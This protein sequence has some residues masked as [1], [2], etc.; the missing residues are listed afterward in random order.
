MMRRSLLIL[1]A[2]CA[3]AQEPAVFRSTTQ[4]IQIDVAAEDKNG[5]PVADLTRDD[6]ELRVSGKPRAIDTFTATSPAPVVTEPLPRGTFSNRT[7]I[8]EVTQ[9]RYTAFVLDCRNTN[10]T[11]QTFAIQQLRKMLETAPPDGKVALYL[12]DNGFQIAQEFTSNPDLLKEKAAGL[13][14][15]APPAVTDLEQAEAAA[16]DTVTAF[17]KI[18]AH[19]AGISGQKIVVWLSTGFPDNEPAPPPVDSPT[20]LTAVRD[21]PG[22][23]FL[24]DIDEAVNILGNANVVLESAEASYPGASVSPD[25]GPITTHVNPLQMIAERTG[26]RFFPA[27]SA[28]MAA[29]L[30]RAAIDHMSGYELGFYDDG[31]RPPGFVPIEVRV[32]RAGVSVRHREGFYAQPVP[33]PA[34]SQDLLERAVDAITIP[35]TAKVTRTAGNH[36]TLRLRLNVDANALTLRQDGNLWRTR[37]AFFTRFAS[38]VEDQVGDVPLDSPELTLTQAQHDRALREGINLRFTVKAKEGAVTLRVLVRD[39]SSGAAGTVTIPLSAI[40]EAY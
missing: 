5:L 21:A 27:E 10:F 18:A 24:T 35:L 13:M 14:A 12:I 20:Q 37:P 25:D 26:G 29:T 22:T 34:T 1:I 32:K 4:L 23:S 40:P 36:G 28:D 15:A 9:G 7:Q 8:S 6:F 31:A 19:L 2:A 11:L 3:L 30:H 39:E 16:K 38:D 33:A 17:R